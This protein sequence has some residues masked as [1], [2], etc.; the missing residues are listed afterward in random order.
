MKV[1]INSDYGGFG[2]SNKAFELLLNKKGIEF[3]KV[4]SKYAMRSEDFDYYKKGHVGEN[5]HYLSYYGEM[6]ENRADPDLVAV[7]EEL[8]EEANGFCA[9][10][11]IVEI[12]DNIE[13]LVNEYDGLEHVA[14]KHRV[15]Y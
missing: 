12:P 9:N 1:I 6:C 10:L 3:E 11:K 5:E 14:E 7:V 15:W 13:W 4:K 2:L 8:G